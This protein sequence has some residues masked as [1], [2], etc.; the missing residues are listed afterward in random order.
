MSLRNRLIGTGLALGLTLGFGTSALAQQPAAQE[1]QPP[2]YG[3]PKP[4][5]RGGHQRMGGLMRML[6]ELNLTQAQEQQARAIL[7]RHRANTTAQRDELR[8]LHEQRGQGTLDAATQE[9]VQ[10]L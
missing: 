3:T 9:R 2:A 5:Q 8:Q 1:Q 4:R 6:R 7:E 10:A